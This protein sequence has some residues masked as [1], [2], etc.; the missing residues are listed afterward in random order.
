MPKILFSRSWCDDDHN[1]IL[2]LSRAHEV[3][4]VVREHLRSAFA[5][6]E[7]P[8]NSWTGGRTAQKRFAPHSSGTALARKLS[9]PYYGLQLATT[10]AQTPPSFISNSRLLPSLHFPPDRSQVFP[11]VHLNLSMYSQV[12]FPNHNRP[13]FRNSQAF[14]RSL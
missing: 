2:S 9:Q 5:P 8:K 7:T 12:C 13:V 6:R 10:A 1:M 14:N 3:D 11:I 4:L